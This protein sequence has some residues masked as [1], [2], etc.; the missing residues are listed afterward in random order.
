MTK[1]EAKYKTTTLLV[2]IARTHFTA[3]GYHNVS[4]ETIAEECEVTRGAVYHHFKSKKGLF[5]AV[6]ERV[7]EDVAVRIKKE[8]SKHDDLWQQLILGCLGFVKGANAEKNRRILLV[9]APVILGW[10]VWR[11]ADRGGS[12][13]VLREH[14]DKLKTQDYLQDYVDV[15]LMTFSVS[16]ALNEL[17]LAYSA[18]DKLGESD[19]LLSTISLLISGFRK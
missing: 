14:I 2:E 8:A 15:D 18:S 11:K 13:S 6:L 16:G 5:I 3:E 4:L 12:M 9:D 17:A 1:E 10:D 7:Q 19:L